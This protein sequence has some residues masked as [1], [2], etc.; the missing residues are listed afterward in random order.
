MRG[1]STTRPWRTLAALLEDSRRLLAGVTLLA[2]AQAALL[3]PVALLLRRIV[4]TYIPA[5]DQRAIVLSGGAV[6]GLYLVSSLLGL[7]LVRLVARATKDGVA[8][9]R[10]EL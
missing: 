3:L 5:A 7:V 6:L 4:D 9:L 8:A 10:H 2:A 1:Q